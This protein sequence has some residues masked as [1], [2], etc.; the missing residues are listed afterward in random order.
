MS[1]TDQIVAALG[2][3]TMF[4]GPLSVKLRESSAATRASLQD[5]K[6]QGRVI[7]VDGEWRVHDVCTEVRQVLA[8]LD[9]GECNAAAVAK[10]LPHLGYD[11][12]EMHALMAYMAA[13]G[14]IVCWFGAGEA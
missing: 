6:L 10:E 14:E 5:A 1:T 11:W 9:G 13:T 4:V 2:D 3:K 7:E 8:G 12:R